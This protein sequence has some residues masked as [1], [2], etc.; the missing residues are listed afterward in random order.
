[1]GIVYLVSFVERGEKVLSMKC[2]CGARMCACH[3]WNPEEVTSCSALSLFSLSLSWTWRRLAAGKP[4]GPP[5]S[6]P[7]RV[8]VADLHMAMSGLF[9]AP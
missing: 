3:T 6:T 8:G 7:Y 4:S 2:V 9:Q 1:M 5:V